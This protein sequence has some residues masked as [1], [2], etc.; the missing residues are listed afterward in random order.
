MIDKFHVSIGLVSAV[1]YIVSS[2]LILL[3]ILMNRIYDNPAIAEI[4][5]GS[6]VLALFAS[7]GMLYWWYTE[8]FSS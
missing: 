2:V 4:Y 3:S 7:V 1:I 8:Q 6:A 5:T